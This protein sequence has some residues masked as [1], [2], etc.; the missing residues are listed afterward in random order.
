MYLDNVVFCHTCEDEDRFLERVPGHEDS[1]KVYGKT[2]IP[3]GKYQLVTSDSA[4]FGR[5]LPEVLNVPGFAGIRVHGGNTAEDSAGCILVG[6][7]KTQTGVA[8]CAN[9]ESKLGWR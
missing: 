2:A 4:H 1:V 5:V 7:V 6:Q 9:W 8:K 3:R